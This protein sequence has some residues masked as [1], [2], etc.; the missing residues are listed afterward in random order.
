MDRRVLSIVT[1]AI[2]VTFVFTAHFLTNAGP[3][4]LPQA[5]LLVVP[6]PTPTSAPFRGSALD[7]KIL[8]QLVEAGKD[9]GGERA[10][11][12]YAGETEQ[13]FCHSQEIAFAFEIG[14]TILAA[15]AVGLWTVKVK[16]S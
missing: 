2:A 16:S 11:E 10:L 8:N 9:T 7:V 5:M 1:A 6:T 12:I 15:L 3:G 14:A 13:R 4:C